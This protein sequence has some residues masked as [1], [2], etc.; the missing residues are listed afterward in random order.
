MWKSCFG[1]VL[2]GEKDSE[3]TRY[4]L[5]AAGDLGII[6]TFV[7]LPSFGEDF[8]FDFSCLEN[9]IVKIDP[10]ESEE[11]YID[12]MTPAA[13]RYIGFLAEIEKVKNVRTLNAPGAIAGVLDKLAC[14]RALEGA[15]LSTTPLLDETDGVGVIYSYAGLRESVLR[16]KIGGVFIKPRFGSGAAGVIAYRMNPRTGSE[17]VYTS[18]VMTGGRLCNTNRVHTVRSSPEIETLVNSILEQGAIVERWIPKASI[19]NGG[20]GHGKSF[21]LR[22]VFQFGRIEFVVARQSDGPVT[23]LHLNNDALETGA[24]HLENRIIDEIGDLCR[25]SVALFPGL[26]SAGIDIL[27]ERASLK[28]Y[29]IEINGQGDLIYKDIFRDNQ[30]YKSQV[31]YL[32]S[33]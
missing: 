15:G 8:T 12:Q 18:A 29:I 31:E 32:R 6:V 10:P 30:I 27:L 3:R 13:K 5:K 7:Q 4:F 23:N 19:F 17:V 1:L 26:N 33:C 9:C 28:P 2:L 22:V 21:D 14:K 16:N 11:T 24:L 25:K 20:F